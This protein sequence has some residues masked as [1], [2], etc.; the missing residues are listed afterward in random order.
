MLSTV[1][2][3][4]I[5]LL[6][7]INGF[8]CRCATLVEVHHYVESAPCLEGGSSFGSSRGF[9]HQGTFVIDAKNI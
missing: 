4:G 1:N 2:P 8:Y 9:Y 5:L 7:L 3:T 6:M